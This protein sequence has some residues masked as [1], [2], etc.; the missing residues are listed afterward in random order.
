MCCKNDNVLIRAIEEK[1]KPISSVILKVVKMRHQLNRQ[2]LNL[3]KKPIPKRIGLLKKFKKN[4][5]TL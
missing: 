4:N 3:K 2:F 5:I 1:T